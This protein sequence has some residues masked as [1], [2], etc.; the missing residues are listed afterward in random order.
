MNNNRPN[1]KIIADLL[2]GE[3]RKV[4]D[5]VELDLKLTVENMPIE[6]RRAAK[7]QILKWMANPDQLITD[8]C[9]VGQTDYDVD[10]VC[11]YEYAELN[12]AYESLVREAVLSNL[13]RIAYRSAAPMPVATQQDW[14]DHYNRLFSRSITAEDFLP[15]RSTTHCDSAGWKK[16]YNRL[17]VGDPPTSPTRTET[18]TYFERIHP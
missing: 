17:F 7:E 1:E 2:D 9:E 3:G 14:H 12:R 11:D 10:S 4:G 18:A 6:R 8:Y 13:P 15:V 5:V 16:I